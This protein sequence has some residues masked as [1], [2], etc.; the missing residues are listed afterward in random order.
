[1]SWPD[2]Q[3]FYNI[4]GTWRPWWEEAELILGIYEDLTEVEKWTKSFCHKKLQPCGWS[5]RCLGSVLRCSTQILLQ[6]FGLW[7]L[8]ASDQNLAKAWIWS[9]LSNWSPPVC[10]KTTGL[11]GLVSLQL[12]I[13]VAVVRGTCFLQSDVRTWDLLALFSSTMCSSTWTRAVNNWPQ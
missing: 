6:W 13:V 1:M 8:L 2:D 10:A 3:P 4:D 9:I 12:F 7:F 11:L 5:I